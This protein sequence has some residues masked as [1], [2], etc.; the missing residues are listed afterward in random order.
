MVAGLGYHIWGASL[1]ANEVR[2]TKEEVRQAKDKAFEALRALDQQERKVETEI[3][4]RQRS[5]AR[6]ES[7]QQ[8]VNLLL[9]NQVSK[10]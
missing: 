8:Q 5:D 9:Q 3:L 1:S 10:K 6:L 7:L 4:L 2:Q